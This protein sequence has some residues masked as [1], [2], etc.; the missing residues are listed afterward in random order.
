MELSE[1]KLIKNKQRPNVC[2]NYQLI[3]NDNKFEIFTQNSGKTFLATKETKRL[4]NRFYIEFSE[5]FNSIKEALS[6]L[7]SL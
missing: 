6:A 1:F 2:Y 4:D 7:S 5:T 3:N